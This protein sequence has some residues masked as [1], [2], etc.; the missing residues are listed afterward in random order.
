M[1]IDVTCWGDSERKIVH[2][3]T[4]PCLHDDLEVV[5]EQILS[6]T[7]RDCWATW[8]EELAIRFLESKRHERDNY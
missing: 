6:V 1:E 4:S 7:C 5:Q 3:P 2:G 8:H